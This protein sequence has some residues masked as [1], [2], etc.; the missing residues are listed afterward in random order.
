VFS[1]SPV[2]LERDQPTGT[3]P[4]AYT[5]LPQ[6]GSD[7]TSAQ[8]VVY[9]DGR[10]HIVWLDT[11]A[12]TCWPSRIIHGQSPL[13]ASVPAE[14][15]VASALRIAPN[16]IRTGSPL[17]VRVRA[18]AHG[19]VALHL[20]DVAGRRVARTE[21]DGAAGDREIRWTLPALR[22]GWYRVT[23]RQ[24]D[25]KLGSASFLVVR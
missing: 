18:E 15:A 23:A 16:P 11:I 3:D 22:A 4:F 6:T 21:H 13:V 20:T 2:Y 10:I 1:F 19:S 12:F 25:A 14:G 8:S 17:Q 24:G 9:H 5:F 7:E